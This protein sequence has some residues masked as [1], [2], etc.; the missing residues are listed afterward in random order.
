MEAIK[1]Q[2]IEALRGALEEMAGGP[3]DVDLVPE[4]PPDPCLVPRNGRT[5]LCMPARKPSVLILS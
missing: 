4:S 1:E 3:L 2:W 5:C